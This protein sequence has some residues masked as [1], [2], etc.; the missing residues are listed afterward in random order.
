MKTSSLLVSLCQ[1]PSEYDK[2][3]PK[4]E[5]WI[6]YA[7]RERLTTVVDLVANVSRMAWDGGD[8]YASIARFLKEFHDTPNRSEQARSFVKELAEHVLRSFAIV[9][10]ENISAD[11]Y[12][13]SVGKPLGE[14]GFIG[15]ASL[16]GHLIERGLLSHEL[17]R[18][19]L[20]KPLIAHHYTDCGDVQRSIRAMAIYELFLAA[21]NTLL[22]GLLEPEDVRACFETLDTDISL[23]GM[24]GPDTEKL[25][26]LSSRCLV[27]E[28]VTYLRP[29]T[30][31]VARCM[32]EAGR[33]STGGRGSPR[34]EGTREGYDGHPNHCR[35]QNSCP[36]RSQKPLFRRGWLRHPFLHLAKLH[37]SPHSAGCGGFHRNRRQHTNCHDLL[38]HIK[39]LHCIRHDPNRAWRGAWGTCNHPPRDILP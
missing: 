21:G 31:R 33:G 4:I 10:A 15:A 8:S 20:V 24:M 5:F 37:P 27:L 1:E 14:R 32:V 28:L 16:I 30:S 12:S 23:E 29:G 22:Q 35:D 2:I 38:P 25:N 19:H 9:S 26:V 18:R 7:L 39:H 36:F 13:G 6:E 11:R 34:T 17:V 3:I